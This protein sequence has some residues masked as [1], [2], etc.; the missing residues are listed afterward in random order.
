MLSKLKNAVRDI[1]TSD[2]SPFEIG[3]GFGIGFFIGF[4][5]VYGFQTIVSV[6]AAALIKRANRV[7]LILATQLFLPFVIPFV[8]AANFFT[9]SLILYG[10]VA[11]FRIQDISDVFIYFLP[12][13]VGSLPNGLLAGFISGYIV[14]RVISS[15]RKKNE[16]RK[17]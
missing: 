17:K 15:N 13:F 2:S 3:Y 11:V 16:K 10:K 5:P 1:L 9:G 12:I 4:I 7:A 8:V 6:L 14:Y